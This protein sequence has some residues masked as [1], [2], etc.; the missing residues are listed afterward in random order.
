MARKSPAALRRAAPR[1][2]SNIK[3]PMVDGVDAATNRHIAV[4]ERDRY[5]PGAV[6]RALTR[7]RAY[8]HGPACELS[9]S[10]TLLYTC[11]PDDRPTTQRAVLETAM[12][13]LP[14]RSAR[15]L[16]TLVASLDQTLLS[17]TYFDPT[18][19]PVLPWWERRLP[20]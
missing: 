9:D 7:W 14:R 15:T 8:V 18:S 2:V 17:R 4:V 16:G 11:C 12:R 10:Y 6:A 5:E 1:H 19:D 13:R 3:V 20:R